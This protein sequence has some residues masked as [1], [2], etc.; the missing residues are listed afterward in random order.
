MTL[1]IFGFDVTYDGLLP[2]IRAWMSD[3]SDLYGSVE[4][5]SLS[6]DFI[7]LAETDLNRE[8]RVREME[9]SATSTPDSS[10]QFTLPT[11]YLEWRSVTSLDS[12]R[13]TLTPVDPNMAE[14]LYG[15][16]ESDLPQNFTIEGSTV[17]IL[18]VS[19][20]DVLFKY[21]R[22]IPAIGWSN[23]TNWLLT[24][25]PHVYLYGCCMHA[26]IYIRDAEDEAHFRGLFM[27]GIEQLRT[28]DKVQRWARYSVRSQGQKP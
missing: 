8:L 17:S 3:R 10:G 19:T 27:A 21:Y 23:T 13:R 26:A 5:D 1:G 4:G 28:D 2:A 24:K 6:D 20:T 12:P 25:A 14:H 15:Y 16:R 22:T 7:R 18:P 9:T 11:D